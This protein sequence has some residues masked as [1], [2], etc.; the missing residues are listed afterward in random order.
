MKIRFT[1]D[2]QGRETAGQAKKEGDVEDVGV[3]FALALI[4]LGVADE[5]ETINVQAF[6]DSDPVYIS[7]APVK[8]KRSL[9]GDQ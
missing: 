7:G 5:L 2:Y 9:K 3:A 4:E 1:K 6:S 8:R